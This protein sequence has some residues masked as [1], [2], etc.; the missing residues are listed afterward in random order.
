MESPLPNPERPYQHKQFDLANIYKRFYNADFQKREL[1]KDLSALRAI[2]AGKTFTE[3]EDSFAKD[4][5][6]QDHMERMAAS[7]PDFAID[8]LY[9][10]VMRRKVDPE[11][12]RVYTDQLHNGRAIKD[13]TEELLRSEEC[14]NTT[15]NQLYQE[16][17]ER[18]SDPEGQKIYADQLASGKPLTEIALDIKQSAEYQYLED[19]NT[20]KVVWWQ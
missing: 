3:T 9:E 7:Y 18:D 12:R 17:L 16:L 10:A 19:K 6:F 20:E 13:I 8:V 2:A 1:P 11:G 4:K 14:R 15:V 5:V